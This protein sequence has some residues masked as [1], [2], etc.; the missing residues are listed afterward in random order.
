MNGFHVYS[1]EHDDDLRGWV[2]I[3]K[4][5]TP[6][7]SK[8]GAEEPLAPEYIASLRAALTSCGWEGDG[9]LG[10]MMVPPFFSS[11]G[12]GTWF[13]IFHV[14]QSN[15]GTSWIASEVPLGTESLNAA[16]RHQ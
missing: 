14:K 13:P 3:D 9:Q 6:N 12:Y 10:G 2:P 4:F 5:R 15:N 1:F 7:W 16:D 8:E 11:E